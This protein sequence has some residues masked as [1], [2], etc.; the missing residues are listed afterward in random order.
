MNLELCSYLISYPPDLCAILYSSMHTV[1]QSQTE[2]V[3]VP[4]LP[5]SHSSIAVCPQVQGLVR[6]FTRACLREHL[7]CVLKALVS[8]Q[9]SGEQQ[10]AAAAVKGRTLRTHLYSRIGLQDSADSGM[11]RLIWFVIGCF[12]RC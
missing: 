7:V 6:L 9:T 8:G 2:A 4:V 5:Q 12:L 11:L 3:C 10:Q 1:Q